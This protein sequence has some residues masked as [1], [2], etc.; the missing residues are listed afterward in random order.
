MK[1]YTLSQRLF[2]QAMLNNKITEENVEE[3]E[4]AFFIS[5]N[6]TEGVDKEYKNRQY[7]K[8]N[9]KNVLILYF[10][11]INE[12][13]NEDD[14]VAKAMDEIQALELLNFINNNKN[15]ET[16]IIHCSAGISRSGAVGSFICDYLKQ[17]YEQFKKDNPI[18]HPNSHVLSILKK[19]SGINY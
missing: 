9:K 19:I 14:L 15:K 6:N 1:I 12:D 17:D 3:K 2:N 5:I 7:F 10:D 16:C 11:D 4:K 8:E 13:V 18:I